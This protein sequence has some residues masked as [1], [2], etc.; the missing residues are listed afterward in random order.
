MSEGRGRRKEQREAKMRH[1]HVVT[2]AGMSNGDITNVDQGSVKSR[3][4]SVDVKPA[5]VNAKDG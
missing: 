4:R 2:A 1:V 5:M 3:S